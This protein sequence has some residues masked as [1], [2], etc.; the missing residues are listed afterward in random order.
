MVNIVRYLRLSLGIKIIEL[1]ELPIM[2]ER[3]F[4]RTK[5]EIKHISPHTTAAASLHV[6]ISL[7]L[8]SKFITWGLVNKTEGCCP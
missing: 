8:A 3:I 6:L 4:Q 2:N 1:I 7:I 5:R